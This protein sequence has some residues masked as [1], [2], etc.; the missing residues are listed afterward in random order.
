MVTDG[1][2]EGTVL[3]SDEVACRD[4]CRGFEAAGA[5]K[6]GAGR[7]ERKRD[8]IGTAVESV[9]EFVVVGTVR[10]AAATAENWGRFATGFLGPAGDNTAGTR[11]AA[12][13]LCA[14]CIGRALI[15]PMADDETVAAVDGAVDVGGAATGGGE[16]EIAALVCT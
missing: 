5:V 7:E 12:E 4:V 9:S 10:A 11:S 3:V 8:C 15:V 13:L 16:E 2:S 6:K 14:G 1:E